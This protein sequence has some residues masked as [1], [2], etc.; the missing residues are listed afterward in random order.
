VE[1]RKEV[2]DRGKVARPCRWQRPLRSS[3]CV[4]ELGQRMAVDEAVKATNGSAQW[5]ECSTHEV[6]TAGRAQ[7][8]EGGV[9]RRSR[10]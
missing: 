10:H 8:S 2:R 1:P 4:R 5:T 3:Q 9:P 7:I 6:G